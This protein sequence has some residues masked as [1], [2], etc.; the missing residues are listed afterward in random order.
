MLSCCMQERQDGVP[1]LM[2]QGKSPK[3]GGLRHLVLQL[4]LNF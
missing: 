1:L 2:V 4:N 3:I